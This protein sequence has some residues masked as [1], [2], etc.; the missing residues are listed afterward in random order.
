MAKPTEKITHAAQRKIYKIGIYGFSGSGKTVIIASLAMARDVHPRGYTCNLLPLSKST[1]LTS[2]SDLDEDALKTYDTR[3]AALIRGHHW[4][5]KAKEE[6][7]R[8]GVP[9]ATPPNIGDMLFEFELTGNKRTF[10]VEVNDYAGELIK[11][12]KSAQ[13]NATRIR[14]AMQQKDAL[15]ILAPAPADDADHSNIRKNL[16]GLLDSFSLLRN[17]KKSDAEF[18]TPVALLINKWDHLG[19]LHYDLVDEKGAHRYSHI[20]S[21]RKVLDQFLNQKPAPAHKE[22]YNVLRNAVRDDCFEMFPVSALG[23]C[24]KEEVGQAKDGTPIIIERPELVDPLYS[25]DLEDAFIWAAEKK[26][27]IDLEQA[28]LALNRLTSSPLRTWLP[29][30]FPAAYAIKDSCWKLL[31]RFPKTVAEYQEARRLSQRS[32]TLFYKRF[33]SSLVTTLALVLGAELSY[34]VWKIRDIAAPNPQDSPDHLLADAQW[35]EAYYKS[36]SLRHSLAK[37]TH[38]SPQD[39]KKQR[40]AILKKAENDYWT[41]VVENSAPEQQ[42]I[43]ANIYLTTYKT[44]TYITEADKIITTFNAAYD[45]DRWDFIRQADSLQKQAGRAEDYINECSSAPKT[46]CHR[47]GQYLSQSKAIIEDARVERIDIEIA[48]RVKTLI[49]D[50]GTDDSMLKASLEYTRFQPESDSGRNEKET[51][52]KQLINKI[53]PFLSDAVERKLAVRNPDAAIELLN[54]HKQHWIA[55]LRP[56]TW[57]QVLDDLYRDVN[58]IKDQLLYADCQIS[59]SLQDCQHYVTN[60][61]IGTMQQQAKMYI[62]YLDKMDGDLE[63][64]LVLS[65]ISLAEKSAWFNEDWTYYVDLDNKTVISGYLSSEGNSIHYPKKSA[66]F[67]GKLKNLVK[68]S[69]TLYDKG[70]TDDVR[71]EGI[72]DV[73]IEALKNLTLSGGGHRFKFT[74]NG[75]PKE[76]SLPDWRAS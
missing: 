39:A 34:D 21:E 53:L 37:R 66:N 7:T 28:T 46:P 72:Q 17:E 51:I 8:R 16:K 29:W 30:P 36:P 41:T 71:H 20:H 2:S 76:P 3:T 50:V 5:N 4:L 45:N 59:K 48:T 58:I 75:I 6:F 42:C 69:F 61:P 32:A 57:N 27:Q 73:Q 60:A 19:K 64:E 54:K 38:L 68:V 33:T 31:R 65:S 15:L 18:E 74:L 14:L 9:P 49:T 24:I 44:G 25:Y 63:L 55:H 56:A 52:R 1:P 35:L 12:E 43:K 23:T 13:E 10:L 47:C 70:T 26:D 67:V 11:P 40:D 22:V 62:D